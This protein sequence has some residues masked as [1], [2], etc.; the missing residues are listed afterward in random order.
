VGRTKGSKNVKPSKTGAV[1]FVRCRPELKAM[2][3]GFGGEQSES[4]KVVSILEAALGAQ[5]ETK[6]E[7]EAE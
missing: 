5:S 1:I 3:A 2:L 7:G 6:R 4:Q